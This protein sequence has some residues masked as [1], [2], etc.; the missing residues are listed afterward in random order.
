[1]GLA[2]LLW[3][4]DSVVRFMGMQ[5][6]HPVFFILAE[7]VLAVLLLLLWVVLR[8]KPLF[9][10]SPKQWFSAVFCGVAGSAVAMV[11]FST[12]ITLMNP[13]VAILLQKLQPIFVTFF[14]MIFL[15]EKPMKH[16]LFFSVISIFCAGVLSLEGVDLKMLSDQLQ[17][18]GLFFAVAAGIL[19]AG[20]TVAGKALSENTDTVVITFWR[21]F[22]GWVA[23]M[24]QCLILRQIDFQHVWTVLQDKDVIIYTVYLSLVP[25]LLAMLLYYRGMSRTKATVVGVIE[26]IYPLSACVLNAIFLGSTLSSSQMTAGGILI[27]TVG[28]VAS[29]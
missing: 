17:W 28:Y 11:F 21:F 22:F 8:K 19:W 9:A 12:S 25:G 24:L 16:F 10:L 20:S 27:F 1:V 14:A 23:L 18:K 2:A 29:H 7:H 26:L 6:A 3:S 5:K 15:G 13:S 4:T